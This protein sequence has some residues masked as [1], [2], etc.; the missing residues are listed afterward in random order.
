MKKNLKKN[1]QIA[2]AETLSNIH[3]GGKELWSE[4][5]KQSLIE[6]IR[7]HGKDWKKIGEQVT[8]KNSS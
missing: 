3:F 4:K 2:D 8:T 5:E 7:E 6:S 1:S